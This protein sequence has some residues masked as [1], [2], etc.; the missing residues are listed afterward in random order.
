MP[1]CRSRSGQD[2]RPFPAHL[3]WDCRSEL[4]PVARSAA[5]H[6][7]SL[8]ESVPCARSAKVPLFEDIRWHCICSCSN[9]ASRNLCWRT[10]FLQPDQSY[11]VV[12]LKP[13][14]PCP[15][16]PNVAQAV[17]EIHRSLLQKPV[18][19]TH[20]P[21]PANTDACVSAERSVS[22]E[23]SVVTVIWQS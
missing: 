21:L 15:H 17:I 14:P 22:F 11:F 12:S 16:S 9:V 1:A 5:L 13:T 23:V 6:R 19:H 4:R 7:R 10:C 3:Q 18:W 2:H 8:L 20:E